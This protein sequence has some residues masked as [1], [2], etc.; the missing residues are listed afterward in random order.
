MNLF[1]IYSIF[2]LILNKSAFKYVCFHTSSVLCDISISKAIFHSDVSDNKDVV[3]NFKYL[4]LILNV[5]LSSLQKV[6]SDNNAL[7]MSYK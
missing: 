3:L 2:D 7:K 1:H 5:L 6:S 4:L